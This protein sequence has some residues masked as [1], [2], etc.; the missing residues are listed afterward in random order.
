MRR[1]PTF[2]SLAVLVTTAAV[3]TSGA[4]ASTPDVGGF[5]SLVP[6]G[7]G[8]TADVFETAA[9]LA[10]GTI[11]SSFENQRAM[12]EALPKAGPGV[13][14]S[15]LGRFF[16]PAPFGV[17]AGTPSETISPRAGTTITRDAY[18]VPHVVG[19]TRA[20][21]MWGA[22]WA[23]AQDRLFLMDVIRRTA[24][25][26]MTAF[27]GPGPN[28]ENV[29]ADVAQRQVTDYTDEELAAMV[30]RLADTGP[31]GAQVVRDVDD[32]L[33][34]VNAYISDARSDPRLMP[35]EY[36]ALAQ[37]LEPFSRADVAAT[38]GLINGYF[39][40]GGGVEIENAIAYRAAWSRFGKAK[41]EKVIA[42]FRAKDDPEAPVTTTRRFPFDDPG[43]PRPAASALPDDGTLQDAG[44]V[45]NASATGG[46][47]STAPH[48]LAT[49]R[50]RGGLRLPRHA[51][52]A[53]AIPAKE[54][55]SGTP[56]F[57]A[58]P[59]VDFYAP[60]LVHEIDLQGPG[61]SVRGVGVPGLGPYVIIGRGKDFAWSI[62][63]AQGDNT[64]TFA[65]RL[66]EPD[67][68]PATLESAHYVRGKTCV[69]LE[70]RDEPVTWRPGPADLSTDPT[71]APYSATFHT[72]RSVHGPIIA[73]AT[74]GGKPVA[75]AL[76][77]STYFHELE[78]AAAIAR[79]NAG[80]R[81]VRDFL[82]TAAR[83]TGSYNLFYADRKNVGYIQSGVYPRR[84]RGTHSDLPAW[85]DG[86]YDWR[87]FDPVTRRASYL[88]PERL[89]QEIDPERGYLLSWNNKQAPGWRASDYDW[90]YG[91]VHRSQ[92]LERRVRGAIKGKRKLTLGGLVGIMGDAGTVDVRGQEAL[93]WMLRVVGHPS[94]PT[95]GHA[96][97]LLRSWRKDG[98]HRVDLDGDGSYDASPAVALMDAWWRPATTAMFRPVL[99]ERLMDAIATI[100]PV[101]YLPTDGPDT[102]FYGW[103]SYVHKDLRAVLG[104]R[105]TQAPSRVYCGRG[106]I[107]RCRT[108]L[109]RTLRDAVDAVTRQYGSLDGAR[110]ATTCPVTQPP[111]CDQLDFIPAGAIELPPT[112]WQ[113]RGSFQQAVEVG[114]AP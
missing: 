28:G 26:R 2:L 97:D 76:A 27:I 90:E 88:P 51:S 19:T 68:S 56:L 42:D 44:V 6:V 107:S 109:R 11:P 64:D 29:A 108:L 78:T 34:G 20:N 60:S 91:S 46:G 87:G 43:P 13:R 113:D 33:A 93:P 69:P 70:Q 10:A 55:A 14:T 63:T 38:V 52:N 71:T 65:E 58:G 102:W 54:S 35:A 15:D 24:R 30:Q 94:D 57:V 112:P 82:S 83:M 100:N 96:A 21:V 98:A 39:G 99:G 3:A 18:R 92:R 59:Q 16:K 8:E 104:R 22:G 32:Y 95:L 9:F 66:C 48:W 72:E 103:M 77:R 86:R 31:E 114:A 50:A 17:P 101:D 67:G 4:A 37:P 25:G 5:H 111:S 61:I 80:T 49:L 7:Q 62:T 1:R 106:S 41:G 89:P 45:R 47:S 36:A 53:M 73:R 75:Y 79:I 85:G 81:G 84:A 110:I 40:R 12:F 74:V 23:V 105:I